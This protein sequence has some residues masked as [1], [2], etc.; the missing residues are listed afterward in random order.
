LWRLFYQ[1]NIQAWTPSSGRLFFAE[2]GVAIKE[3][4]LQKQQLKGLNND[5]RELTGAQGFDFVCQ[6]G[7]GGVADV[8]VGVCPGGPGSSEERQGDQMSL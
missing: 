4:Y 8:L 5:G 6:A 3:D 2:F 7:K 1:Q